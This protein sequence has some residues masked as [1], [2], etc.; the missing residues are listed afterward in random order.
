MLTNSIPY[1]RTAQ[2]KTP[3]TSKTQS[4]QNP[5]PKP[6]SNLYS[7]HKPQ[8]KPSK[9]KLL[10]TNYKK[11]PLRNRILTDFTLSNLPPPYTIVDEK[12]VYESDDSTNQKF[13]KMLELA[14]TSD[15]IVAYSDSGP[16]LADTWGLGTYVKRIDLTI[17]DGITDPMHVPTYTEY[18]QIVNDITETYDDNKFFVIYQSFGRDYSNYGI[19]AQEINMEKV[20]KKGS[21]TEIQI[22]K[23]SFGEQSRGRIQ[24]YVTDRFIIVYFC[25]DTSLIKNICINELDKK[26]HYIGSTLKAGV[27]TSDFYEFP[28]LVTWPDNRS[29]LVVYQAREI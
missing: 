7:Y 12:V 18:D 8:K 17:V 23:S 6:Q 11:K 21:E 15:I 22:N 13:P 10:F 27:T 20:L 26:G 29:F 25:E 3:T 5:I 9:P 24:K 14:T 28:K 2:Q 4:H 1:Q 19:F 16:A